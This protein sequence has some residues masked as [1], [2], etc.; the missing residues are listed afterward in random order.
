MTDKM[1]LTKIFEGTVARILDQ[2]VLMGNCEWDSEVMKEATNISD[3]G[4]YRSIKLLKKFGIVISEDK[5]HNDRW[6]K[7]YRFNTELCHDLIIFLNSMQR[8]LNRDG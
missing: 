8:K 6:H 5:F 2:I 1:P 3:T 7:Y 4:F